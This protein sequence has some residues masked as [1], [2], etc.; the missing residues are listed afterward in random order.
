MTTAEDKAD[1]AN[2]GSRKLGESCCGQYGSDEN[3]QAN[4]ILQMR[5][6]SILLYHFIGNSQN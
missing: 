2:D 1:V 4:A 3:G 6:R 5:Q